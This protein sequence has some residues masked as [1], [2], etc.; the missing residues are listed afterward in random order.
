MSRTVFILGA[1][2]SAEAGVPLMKNSL[3]VAE[4]LRRNEIDDPDIGRAFDTVFKGIS[5][6]RG[7][8]ATTHLD[9]NNLETVFA[10]FE[11]GKLLKRLANLNDE[12]LQGLPADMRTLIL[13]TVLRTTVLPRELREQR[14][15][16]ESAYANFVTILRKLN[17]HRHLGEQNRCSVITFNY[18]LALDWVLWQAGY[19]VFYAVDDQENKRGIPVLKLHGSVNW[20]RCSNQDCSA[21][22]PWLGD[23]WSVVPSGQAV[24]E[25][26]VRIR[27][28]DDV[29][30]TPQHCGQ[31][32][33]REPVIVPPTWNKTGH[34]SAPLLVWRQAAAELATAEEIIVCGYSLPE[35]DLF[36]KYL[37]ALGTLHGARPRFFW[38]FDPNPQ[39]GQKFEGLLGDLMRSGFDFAN[40]KFSEA[41]H[42]IAGWL[43]REDVSHFRLVTMP[44]PR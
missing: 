21:I 25:N 11:M 15:A 29:R 24:A 2:A 20:T 22:V 3:D 30:H 23:K 12:E 16:H 4:D 18:D 38:V 34:E 33:S 39:V 10:A 32:V 26:R 40:L 1:G 42:A 13:E 5:A 7:V 9:L 27:L 44:K 43:E 37:F 19:P 8:P 35:T 36:F 14:L 6:L 28:T 41:V 17:E 31:P